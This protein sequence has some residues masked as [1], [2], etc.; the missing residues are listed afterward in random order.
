MF[1]VHVHRQLRGAVQ[2]VE[3]ARCDGL[4]DPFDGR[5][6]RRQLRRSRQVAACRRRCGRRVAAAARSTSSLVM[7]PPGPRA[8]APAQDRRRV[9]RRGV[10]RAAMPDPVAC[11][12]CGRLPAAAV[13]APAR[14]SASTMRPPGPLPR[15]VVNRRSVRRPGGVRRGRRRH[16]RPAARRYGRDRDARGA[17]TTAGAAGA[18]SGADGAAEGIVSPG[19]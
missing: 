13:A 17:V 3:H 19:A 1:D 9:P 12:C 14:T 11:R 18:P 5:S 6:A 15:N 16:A 2:A 4:A 8:R 10:L 7:R